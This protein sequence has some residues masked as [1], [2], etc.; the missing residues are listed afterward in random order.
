MNSRK[1]IAAALA[2]SMIGSAVAQTTPAPA[3][4]PSTSTSEEVQP[5]FVW[6][7]LIQLAVSRVGGFAWDIF[8][9][10]LETKLT[11]G[12]DSLTDRMVLGLTSSSGA[13]IAS[14]SAEVAPRA[15]PV[16]G[17]PDKPLSVEN[18]KENYQ[19]ANIAILAGA[20]GSTTFEAR[21]VNAGFKTGERFKLRI[22]STFGGELTLEN[23]N[24]KGDRRQIYPASSAEVV[25]LEPG[26]ETF[27][28]L[29]PDEFFEFTGES[30]KEQL[31][32][33]LVD[34]RATSG[35]ASTNK[36]FRQDVKYG[37]NF[38]QEVGNDTFANI[39]QA[40]EIQHSP[41]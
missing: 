9:R 38:V 23:I 13:R 36:V 29:G 35:H 31:I 14:R 30:G 5:R 17:T 15:A 21:A 37:S 28:P 22:V 33:N 24:P 19:G 25:R 34:P 10:W 8:T 2:A 26:K 6:G 40:I 12:L 7:I 1:A 4:A 41:E 18:G 20:K 32:V 39:T 11:G 16:I 27:I 3:P